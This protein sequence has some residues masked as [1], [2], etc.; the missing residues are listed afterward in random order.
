MDKTLNLS[1]CLKYHS[2][3]INERVNLQCCLF[4]NSRL[5]AGEWFTS[6]SDLF[7]HGGDGGSPVVSE[8]GFYIRTGLDVVGKIWFTYPYQKSNWVGSLGCAPRNLSLR[9]LNYLGLYFWKL[10]DEQCRWVAK[11]GVAKVNF[12]FHWRRTE[13]TE[14]GVI[15]LLAGVT[16]FYLLQSVQTG[17][18]ALT[19]YSV[20]S[21]GSFLRG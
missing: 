8:A 17:A 21:S 16:H 19:S 5:D 3:N 6:H 13:V 9:R 2:V 1:P 10:S 12:S 11:K 7:E 20:D 18:V 4:L 14:T 15:L